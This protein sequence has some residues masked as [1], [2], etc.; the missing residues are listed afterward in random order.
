MPF[1]G[2]FAVAAGGVA[3]LPT[4]AKAYRHPDSESFSFYVFGSTGAAITLLTI[5]PWSPQASAFAVYQ[6]MHCVSLALLII[7]R[8]RSARSGVA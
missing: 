5:S 4:L 3:A 2:F 8:R 1:I 6:L 7:W